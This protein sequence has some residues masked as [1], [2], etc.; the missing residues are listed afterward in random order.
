MSFVTNLATAATISIGFA[1]SVG[2]ATAG[3]FDLSRA[4]EQPRYERFIN[5][6]IY[7]PRYVHRYHTAPHGDPY[8]YRYARRAYYPYTGSHYWVASE[9]MHNRYRYHWS[10][11]KYEYQ[12]SWG[13]APV[14]HHHHAERHAPVRPTK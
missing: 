4:P 12:P 7:K 5:H 6:Y 11:P 8:A 2:S 3:S 13:R 14:A 1:A 10:G 9:Q